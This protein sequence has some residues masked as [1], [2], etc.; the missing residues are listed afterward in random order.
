MLSLEHFSSTGRRSSSTETNT[1]MLKYDG[2]RRERRDKL[3][4]LAAITDLAAFP[5][6]FST[7]I[8]RQVC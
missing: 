1:G 6:L 4:N 5:P 7:F 3:G 8:V 2:Q